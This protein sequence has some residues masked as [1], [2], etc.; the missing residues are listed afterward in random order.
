MESMKHS[1][2]KN[3]VKPFIN[4]K[5]CPHKIKKRIYLHC[6][7]LLM[8]IKNKLF[9]SAIL[10]DYQENN[11]YYPLVGKYMIIGTLIVIC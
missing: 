4:S 8:T 9:L 1:K 10:N 7:K 5:L 11:A 3:K 6:S 2:K